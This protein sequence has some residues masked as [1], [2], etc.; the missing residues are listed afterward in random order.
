MPIALMRVHEEL[1]MTKKANVNKIKRLAK[2][3]I[4]DE[5][6]QSTTEYVLL[7]LML[8]VAVRSVGNTFKTKLGSL[9]NAVFTQAESEATSAGTN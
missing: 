8:V 6:G 1:H 2:H 5:S 7:V 9:V 3:W 4:S